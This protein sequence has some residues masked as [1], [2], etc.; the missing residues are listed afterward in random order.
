MQVRVIPVDAAHVVARN[1]KLVQSPLPRQHTAFGGVDD[2]VAEDTGSEL[3]GID[4]QPV[5]VE[6]R[7]V[8][9]PEVFERRAIRAE[10]EA[11]C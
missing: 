7:A 2:V 8:G 11:G 6:V 4:M 5:E 9:K 1:G 3:P 10:R